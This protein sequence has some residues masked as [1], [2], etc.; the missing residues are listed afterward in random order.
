VRGEID[1]HKY[2]KRN[3]QEVN[4]MFSGFYDV[5]EMSSKKNVEK[6]N[7]AQFQLC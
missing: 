3:A 7:Y 6:N 4:L 5:Y 2:P 1:K